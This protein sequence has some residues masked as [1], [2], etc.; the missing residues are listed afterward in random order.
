MVADAGYFWSLSRYIHLNPCSR[1]RPLATTPDGWK[2]SSYSG[3]ARN[4]ERV[5]WIHDDEL[6]TYWEGTKGSGL[7][8]ACL[9]THARIK[10]AC[11]PLIFAL[12]E[13]KGEQGPI[14]GF[15]P[16]TVLFSL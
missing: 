4:S 12:R 13:G 2:H 8:Q 5:D 16:V 6:H 10:D 1:A 3:Y 14:T 7:G 9:F 15:G 11:P